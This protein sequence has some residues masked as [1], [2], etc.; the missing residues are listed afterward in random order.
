MTSALPVLVASNTKTFISVSILKLWEQGRLDLDDPIAMYLPGEYV[1][2]LRGDSYD[3]EAVTI[4]H[5]LTHT[6]GLFD[7]ADSDIYTDEIMADP[8]HRWTRAEQL[9]AAMEW[10]DP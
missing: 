3:P 6:S 1:E 7:F 2:L 10:G 4:R 9:E 8:K 5:L